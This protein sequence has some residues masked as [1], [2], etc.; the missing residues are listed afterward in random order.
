MTEQSRDIKQGVD[1]AAAKAKA[2]P[3]KARAIR[4]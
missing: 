1:E 4:D 3:N 2:R